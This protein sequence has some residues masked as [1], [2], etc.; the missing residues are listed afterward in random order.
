[1][2]VIPS[3]VQAACPL[4]VSESSTPHIVASCWCLG[5]GSLHR[6]GHGGGTHIQAGVCIWY[7]C[8]GWHLHLDGDSIVSANMCYARACREECRVENGV[9]WGIVSGVIGHSLSVLG[10]CGCLSQEVP[11]AP[12]PFVMVGTHS[13]SLMV[14]MSP[15]CCLLVMIVSGCSCSLILV[16]GTHG[17]DGHWWPAV[18]S[19]NGHCGHYWAS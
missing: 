7:S 4:P 17:G 1:M 13:H 16:V 3:P 19:G 11:M 14:V 15:F 6:C 10:A 18:N 5:H 9:G 8:L 12:W 2:M